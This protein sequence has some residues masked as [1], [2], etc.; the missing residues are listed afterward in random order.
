MALNIQVIPIIFS[1]F[2]ATYVIF[3]DDMCEQTSS[4]YLRPKA[5]FP[6]IYTDFESFDDLHFVCD[7]LNLTNY[8]RNT[9][10]SNAGFVPLIPKH[11]LVI[12]ST[13]NLT[14]FKFVSRTVGIYF[15]KTK[16][17]DLNS[18][19]VVEVT[20][21]SDDVGLNFQQMSLNFYLERTNCG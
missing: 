15:Q 7:V 18:K 9:L 10:E 5:P 12:N 13:L 19:L 3:C 16:G 14:I 8:F 2:L 4:K 21:A 20:D 17:F 11:E 1:S 6:L